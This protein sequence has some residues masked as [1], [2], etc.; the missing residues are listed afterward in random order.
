MMP[1][2]CETS[3]SKAT[4]R[5]DFDCFISNPSWWCTVQ[6]NCPNTSR[7]SDFVPFLFHLSG[8]G[9]LTRESS[10][11][12][13]LLRLTDQFLAILNDSGDLFEL[14]TM[15]E[16]RLVLAESTNQL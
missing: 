16:M 10:V 14:P 6:I 12:T 4:L 9:A 8:Y 15:Y 1:Y 2:F 5:F 13:P 7:P 11:I 3:C